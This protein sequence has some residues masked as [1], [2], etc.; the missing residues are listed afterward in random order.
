MFFCVTF[1]IMLDF[2]VFYFLTVE[3]CFKRFYVFIYTHTEIHIQTHVK[4]KI[5]L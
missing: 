4:G 5:F 3:K 2:S 1:K